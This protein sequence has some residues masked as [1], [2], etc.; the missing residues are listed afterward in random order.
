[1]QRTQFQSLEPFPPNNIMWHTWQKY[2]TA[3]KSFS[4]TQLPK[5]SETFYRECIINFTLNN[6]TQTSTKHLTNMQYLQGKFV[7]DHIFLKKKGTPPR[8]NYF[9]VVYVFILVT[10]NPRLESPSSGYVNITND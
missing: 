5:D 7:L 8:L 1:M 10:S 9:T 2:I 6:I 3:G 4:E